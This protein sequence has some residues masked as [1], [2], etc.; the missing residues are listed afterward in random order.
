MPLH[1][2]WPSPPEREQLGARLHPGDDPA[3]A[4]VLEWAG[5]FFSGI[6]P[7]DQ[8]ERS[9]IPEDPMVFATPGLFDAQINGYWG[10]GFKD[11]EAGPQGVRDLCWSITLSGTTRFLPTITTDAPEVM[12]A[13]MANIDA[14][15]RAYPDVAAMVAGIHQEGPWISPVDG[16]RGAHPREHVAPPDIDVF[17]LL[18]ESSGNRIRLLTLAPEING[19][20]DLI[21]EVTERGMSVCLGHHQ[22]ARST[23]RQA[24]GAGAVGVTHLG[25]GCHNMMP[26]HPNVLWEQAAEDRLFAGVISDG[27]HVPPA[28][29][30]VF[31]RAKP[32]GKLFL[33]SDAVS[34]AGAP[35]GLYHLRDEIVEMRPSGRFGFYESET[36]IGAAV[37]LSRCLANFVDFTDEGKTPVSYLPHV[38]RVP[39]MLTGISDLAAPLGKPG[40]PATFVVWRWD[41]DTPDLIPQRIVVRGR[42]VYDTNTL[43]TQVPFGRT[44]EPA[45][46]EEA[47]QSS[48]SSNG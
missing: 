17:D 10:R 30:K 26:R 43:P 3:D 18:Q 11:V 39:G 13:A 9:L 40:T 45:T 28:T 1:Y 32:P 23:I 38:T 15:C 41:R 34:M 8:K 7:A 24:I 22:A 19:G 35:P 25:N 44:L 48:L 29:V 4:V 16:P 2:P 21:R 20:I 47:E 42:T 33:V 6:H 46:S 5:E 27:H 37:S 36:L 31:Y 12:R 14:A